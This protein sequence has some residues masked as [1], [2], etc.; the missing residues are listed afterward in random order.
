MT[1]DEKFEF[2][3]NFIKD[4]MKELGYDNV[5][6]TRGPGATDGFKRECGS[7]DSDTKTIKLADECLEEDDYEDSLD[8]VVHEITHAVDDLESTEPIEYSEEGFVKGRTIFE[9][10]EVKVIKGEIKIDPEHQSVRDF[11]TGIVK[12][13]LSKCKEKKDSSESASEKNMPDNKWNL[14]PDVNK[15]L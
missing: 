4:M 5:K 8:T 12:L 3:K 7:W 14:P 2:S 1:G 9:D 11:T 10:G 13:L 6:I 15:P